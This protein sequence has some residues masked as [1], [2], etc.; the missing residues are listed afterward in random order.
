MFFQ[1]NFCSVGEGGDFFRRKVW[2]NLFSI[3]DFEEM[4]TVEIDSVL[5]ETIS[6]KISKENTSK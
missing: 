2:E 5:Y 3:I 1:Y 4:N 6:E